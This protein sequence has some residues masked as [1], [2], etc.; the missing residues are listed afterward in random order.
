MGVKKSVAAATETGQTPKSGHFQPLFSNLKLRLMPV[1]LY[2]RRAQSRQ[3]ML[4]DRR[5]PGQEFVNG[6]SIAVARLFEAQETER[7]TD[8]AARNPP[9]IEF[10]PAYN[11]RGGCRAPF[12]W[13]ASQENAGFGKGKPWLPVE[14]AHLQCAAGSQE[15]DLN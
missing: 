12:P 14:Q 1:L 2:P 4:L 5:L 15:A 9:C 8:K 6:Q 11:G 13:D 10:W 7:A 3:P